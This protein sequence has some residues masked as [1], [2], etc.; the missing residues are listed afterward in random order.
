MEKQKKTSELLF[1]L[2][3]EIE[4][5]DW[6]FFHLL[7]EKTFIILLHL[8]SSSSL[9]SSNL[10]PVFYLLKY[11]P[12]MTLHQRF[13]LHPHPPFLSLHIFNM[14]H[15]LFLQFYLHPCHPDHHLILHF[16]YQCMITFYSFLIFLNSSGDLLI[17]SWGQLPD[18]DNGK[19]VI[20]YKGKCRLIPSRHNYASKRMMMNWERNMKKMLL[21]RLSSTEYEKKTDDEDKW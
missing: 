11:L 16:V 1:H 20:V 13:H 3:S 10:S 21:K 8:S 6:D 12:F 19:R 14:A 15:M 9:S 7:I 17:Q 5:E 2:E 4:G 18:D